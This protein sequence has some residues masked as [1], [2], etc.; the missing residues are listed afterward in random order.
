M[1][2][3]NPKIREDEA[4]Y[5]VIWPEGFGQVI[6]VNEP[7]AKILCERTA[8]FNHLPSMEQ[9]KSRIQNGFGEMRQALKEHCQEVLKGL[10]N[11]DLQ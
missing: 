7:I 5:N 10:K 4:A 6:E 2:E 1:Q 8:E 9:R 11:E 3:L